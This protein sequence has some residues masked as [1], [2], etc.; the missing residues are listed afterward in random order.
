MW[1][2]Y[3]ILHTEGGVKKEGRR[4][5]KREWGASCKWIIFIINELNMRRQQQRKK[6]SGEEEGERVS[7]GELGYESD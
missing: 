2:H 4:E 6:S 3:S 5:R 1:R 7:A